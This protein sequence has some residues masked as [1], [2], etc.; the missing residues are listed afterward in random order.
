[1]EQRTLISPKLDVVFKTLF[2]ENPD[3]LLNFVASIL[4]VEPESITSLQ[5]T[6]PELT[7]EDVDGKFSRL[8]LKLAVDDRLMNLEIQVRNYQD[9]KDRAMFYWAKLFTSELKSGY[10]YGSLKETITVNILDFNLFDNRDD[11]Y[12]EVIPMIKGTEEIF[13]DK[14]SIRFLELRKCKTYD[15][16]NPLETWLQFLNANTEE[17]FEMVQ[18]VGNEAINNAVIKIYNMSADDRM[19]ERAWMREKALHDEASAMADARREGLLTGLTK[20]REEGR[21]EGR[22]EGKAAILAMLIKAGK[23]T[24]EEALIYAE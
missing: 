13:T 11:Y 7:P 6:N 18:S 21:V 24:K 3:L 5:V 8:D 9:Y 10:N 19:R 20:G 2:V 22:A 23:L 16:D 1:M 15:K 4:A 17:D 12:T 14:M